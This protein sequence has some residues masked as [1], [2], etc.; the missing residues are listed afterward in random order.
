MYFFP[1]SKLRNIILPKFAPGLT[2]T[3]VQTNSSSHKH[4]NQA[5]FFDTTVPVIENQ[6]SEMFYI[7]TSLI[8]HVNGISYVLFGVSEIY[9]ASG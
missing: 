8:L 9:R 3:S 1:L 5:K 6:T 7:K 4:Q 2:V